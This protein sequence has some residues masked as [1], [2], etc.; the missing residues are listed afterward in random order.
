[1]SPK[2]Y[3]LSTLHRQENVDDRARLTEIFKGLGLVSGEYGLPVVLP[4]HPRT[5]KM[6]E[7]FGLKMPE[8]IRLAEPVG[9]LEFLEAESNAR[10]VLTDSGGVQEGMLHPRRALCHV[11]GKHRAA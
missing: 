1:M 2:S 9:F 10:L 6:I 5:R 11:A 4:V 7:A 3:L 8:N